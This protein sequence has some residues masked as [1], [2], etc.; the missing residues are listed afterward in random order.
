MHLAAKE[1][2]VGIAIDGARF[3]H[4]PSSGGRVRSDSI[5]AAPYRQGFI[6]AR[7]IIADR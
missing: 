6:G 5:A 7:R 2:H 4:A 3:I 1:L